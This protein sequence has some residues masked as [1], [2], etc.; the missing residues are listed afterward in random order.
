MILG[1]DVLIAADPPWT[2]TQEL[3]SR[4]GP[5]ASQQCPPL[6]SADLGTD[7]GLGGKEM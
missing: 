1:L 4:Q 2:D 3:A 6:S 5:P 7:L